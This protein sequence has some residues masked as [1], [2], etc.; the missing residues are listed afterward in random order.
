MSCRGKL[1]GCCCSGTTG[2][3]FELPVPQFPHMYSE[4]D[5]NSLYLTGLLEGLNILT[6]VR[7]CIC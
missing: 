7:V 1:P 4:N 5:S 2:V 6:Y 3:L